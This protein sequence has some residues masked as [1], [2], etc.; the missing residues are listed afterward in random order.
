MI[1]DY[2]NSLAEMLAANSR[3]ASSSAHR[4]DTGSNREQLLINLLNKHLP[5]RLEA[6]SGG[7][8]VNLA[9]ELSRQIDV[10]VKNDLFPKFN[11]HERTIVICESVAGVLSVKSWLD[12]AALEESIANVG[13]I[14]SFFRDTLSLSNSSILRDNLQQEFT[15]NWP[16]RAIFAYDGIDPDTIYRHA[17]A[18]CKSH[19][20]SPRQLPDMIIVNKKLCIRFL[21]GGGT[22]QDG[23]KLPANWLHPLKLTEATYGYPI[24]GMISELNNYVPWM[25]YMKFNFAPYVDKAYALHSREVTSE[26]AV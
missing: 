3:S 4:P 21:R 24:A 17:L 19:A 2:F 18:C 5:D 11:Q 16:F 26:K 14:P 22:L 20:G 23:T 25:H 7:T 8:V 10:I 13:S 6:V 15:Q 1:G 12:K 9:G